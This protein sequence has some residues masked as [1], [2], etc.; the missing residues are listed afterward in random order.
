M[1]DS[2]SSFFNTP[3][4]QATSLKESLF[5]Y[6]QLTKPN[7]TFLVVLTTLLGMLFAHVSSVS[8]AILVWTLV[9]T[10]LSAA[11]ACVLNMY[12][13]REEDKRMD[14]TKHRPLPRGRLQPY[15]ALAWG[16]VLVLSGFMFLW[17]IVNA[18]TALLSLLAALVYVL[19]YTPLKKITPWAVLVGAVPGAMPPLMGSTAL[20]NRLTIEGL[21]VFLLLFFWQLPHFLALA[22]LYQ[23][24][25]EQGGFYVLP[26]ESQ[27]YS[28][29][30]LGILLGTCCLVATS[31]AIGY[32]SGSALYFGFC[33]LAN[34]W[35][36]IHVFRFIKTRELA[37]AKRLFLSTLLYL[38]LLIVGLVFAQSHFF[39]LLF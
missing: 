26:K 9:G 32:L 7:L 33:G 36:L 13:E 21:C 22:L 27:P 3:P 30:S 10:T 28:K 37:F 18:L 11:G 6:Y 1:H 16:C 15:S 38:P 4:W 23:K 14:R 17:G 35:L 2:S 8:W 39:L 24:D 20:D 19:I 12:L 29:T 34:T 25:Y 5:D 31:I